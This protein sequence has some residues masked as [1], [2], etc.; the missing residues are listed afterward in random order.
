MGPSLGER[1]K[2]FKIIKREKVT[3]AIVTWGTALF[4]LNLKLVW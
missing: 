1:I 4:K 2:E 3:V